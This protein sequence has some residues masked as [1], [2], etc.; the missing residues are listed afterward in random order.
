MVVVRVIESGVKRIIESGS[1]GGGGG[2]GEDSWNCDVVKIEIE[3]LVTII[4]RE[5]M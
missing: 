2:G 1:G 3:V 4:W 5:I